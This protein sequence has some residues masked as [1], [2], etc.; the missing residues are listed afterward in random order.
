MVV[1]RWWWWLPNTMT[2]RRKLSALLRP[3]AVDAMAAKIVAENPLCPHH[4]ML[5]VAQ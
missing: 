3:V 1:V 5:M 4:L 2:E